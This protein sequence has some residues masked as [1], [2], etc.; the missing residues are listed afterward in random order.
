MRP[1]SG[2]Q[3]TIAV[4]SAEPDL[5]LEVHRATLAALSFMH[6]PRSHRA[7]RLAAGI[8]LFMLAS[9]FGLSA[10]D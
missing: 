5:P 1:M 3:P 7:V 4:H 9:L 10:T 2:N 8:A 6:L